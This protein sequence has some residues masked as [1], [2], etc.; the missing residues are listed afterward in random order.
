M[1][2]FDSHAHYND[3][4]FAED[5]AQLIAS[6][7]FQHVDAV[8]EIGF[9]RESSAA[10]VRLAEQNTGDTE[11]YAAV[12]IH[13][14]EAGKAREEDLKELRALAAHPKVVALG[15]IGLDYYWPEPERDIQQLWFRRQIQLGQELGLPLIIH[16]REAAKDT[17]DILKEMDGARN[18]G[19]I[20]CFSY[21]EEMAM[22]FVRMGMHIGIGGVLSFKN[23]KKL[24]EAAA[25]IPIECIVLET[26]CPYMAPEPKRGSRNDSSNLIYVAERL[27]EIKGISVEEVIR[28]TAE[29]ARN[30]Y[31][32]KE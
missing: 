4:A 25:A 30:V 2:I 16:S 22:Q 31:R 18:G 13:P 14:E 15:E 8:C 10:A 12:G 29:N 27:A 9:D 6:L 3:R 20:H 28:I 5:R 17:Y 24:R 7:S 21:S 19:I 26:D 1:R 11:F 23:A 32:I